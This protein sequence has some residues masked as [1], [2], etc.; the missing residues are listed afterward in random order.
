MRPVEI[1]LKADLRDTEGY[2]YVSKQNSENLFIGRFFIYLFRQIFAGGTDFIK[3]FNNK[4]QVNKKR[5]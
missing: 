1:G 3:L 4:F 2:Y 5:I